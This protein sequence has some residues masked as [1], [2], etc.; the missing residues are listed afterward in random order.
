MDLRNK[1][2]DTLINLA[3]SDDKIFLITCDLGYNFLERFRDKFPKQYLNVGIIEQSAVGIAAGMAI[4][5]FKPYVYSTAPFLFSRAAEFIR[6]DVAYQNLNVKLI[7]VKMSGFIGFTHTT[8]ND[9][10][11]KFF[12]TLPNIK[13]Y[14]P[15]DEE[16]AEKII[17]E[18]YQQKIP[19]YI[20]I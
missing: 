7:G 16:E 13:A 8:Y 20:R 11:L 18:T 5:N 4:S 6:D 2:V 12:E 15:K 14:A 9:E 19:S 10:D 3:E 17:K 1:F